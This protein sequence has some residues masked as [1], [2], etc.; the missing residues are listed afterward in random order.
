MGNCP[1][2]SSIWSLPCVAASPLFRY[3][4]HDTFNHFQR[5]H[6]A[7]IF[8]TVNIKVICILSVD[9]PDDIDSNSRDPAAHSTQVAGVY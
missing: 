5:T 8:D 2:R 4:V 7:Y 1:A 3:V 6:A 9:A